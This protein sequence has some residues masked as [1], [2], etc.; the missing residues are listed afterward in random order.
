MEPVQLNSK[1]D[2]EKASDYRAEIMP[3][4]D[5]VCAVLNRSKQ[6]GLIINVSLPNDVFGRYIPQISIVKP[7]A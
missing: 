1:N 3:L 2:F 4:L 6:D 5:Q 7:I